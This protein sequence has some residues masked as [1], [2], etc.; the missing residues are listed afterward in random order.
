MHPTYNK[1]QN[2]GSGAGEMSAVKRVSAGK[3]D[4]GTDHPHTST[5]ITKSSSGT[6]N[7]GALDS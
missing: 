2:P 3:V 4:T 5:G 1:P 7:R 6:S